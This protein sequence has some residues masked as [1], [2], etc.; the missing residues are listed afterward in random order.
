MKATRHNNNSER[1][2]MVARAGGGQNKKRLVKRLQTFC[3]KMNK[4]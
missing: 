1:E 3:Y 4:V 2:N